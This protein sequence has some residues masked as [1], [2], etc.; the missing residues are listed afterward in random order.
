MHN[1]FY[2][3][4]LSS[5]IILVCDRYYFQFSQWFNNEEVVILDI[6]GSLKI[7]K[8]FVVTSSRKSLM[9]FIELVD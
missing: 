3:F 1:A 2:I 4:F 5:R 7:M 8:R 9:L 6:F